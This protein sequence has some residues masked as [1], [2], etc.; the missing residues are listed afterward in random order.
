[1]QTKSFDVKNFE[2]SSFDEV[3]SE[4]SVDFDRLLK[5]KPLP[6]N[7]LK[8]ESIDSK[9]NN[10]DIMPEVKKY[11]GIKAKEDEEREEKIDSIVSEKLA[12][13]SVEVRKS[14]F[15]KGRR[16]G[17]EEIKRELLKSFR[18]ELEGFVAYIEK[19]KDEYRNILENQKYEI[20][21]L[22][23][24]LTKWVILK[25]LR[26]DGDYLKRLVHK[27]LLE[28]DS[29]SNLL[30]KV[31]R[32]NFKRFPEILNFFEEQ[33]EGISNSRVE[34]IQD[35]SDMLG[36]GIVIESENG[37]LDATFREQFKHLD[38][39]FDELNKSHES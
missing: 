33:F 9:K 15:E 23:N 1:M 29:H 28:L 36:R 25:E 17:E 24:S 18:E 14:G 21:E 12:L 30:I 7:V 32:E 27:L 8:K 22:V 11:R 3:S 10:F 16:E 20:Y 13:C 38:S 6:P 34:V 35:D 5:K 31:N 37:I 2:I 26:G 4:N 19:A 39:L